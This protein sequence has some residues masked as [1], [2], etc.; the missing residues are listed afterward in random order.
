MVTA[1]TEM[2]VFKDKLAHLE[3]HLQTLIEGGAAWLF[4]ARGGQDTPPI[5]PPTAPADAETGTLAI[6]SEAAAQDL[7][8]EAFLILSDDQVF[9]LHH[10]VLNIGRRV[11][12]HLMIDDPRVSR[13]HAQL[14]ANRDHYVIFDLDSSG[15]TFVNG[16][17]IHQY[18]LRSGD[19]I[20]LAGVTMVFGQEA[21]PAAGTTQKTTSRQ[22]NER[23][24]GRETLSIESQEA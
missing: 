18:I 7:P 2:N 21:D 17:R 5:P 6:E 4:P 11:D 12:N 13:L 1:Q 24:A 20:L 14:R 23:S 8:P 22:E 15:G 16:E 19:V 3:S 10:T 9:A